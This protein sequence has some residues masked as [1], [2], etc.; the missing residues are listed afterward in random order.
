MSLAGHQILVVG[1]TGA[2]GRALCFAL[3]AQGAQLILLGRRL[4]A[5][6]RLDDELRAAGADP[7][8]Y[9]LNLEGATAQ[10]YADLAQRL[11]ELP[12]GLGGLCWAAGQFSGL[13]PLEDAE[14]D[15]WLRLVHVNLH[16]PAFALASL[17]PVL[18]A[19]AGF[20]L[21]PLADPQLTCNAY[22]GAYGA[23][24]AGLRNLLHAVSQECEQQG[25]QVLGV[26]LPALRSNVR[27]KAFPAE[28]PT[29]PVE[30]QV[31]VPRLLAA[32]RHGVRGVHSW[33]DLAVQ[34]SEA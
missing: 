16:A 12:G 24:Q 30:A 27:L 15:D 6:E 11:A 19:S 26:Q 14:F 7:A 17:L 21:V 8:L 31:V 10:D 34:P 13:M 20:V 23:A 2:L 5:L 3:H 29:F 1:A 28:D 18:R 25:P 4:K 9:P 33:S 32:V 22:W